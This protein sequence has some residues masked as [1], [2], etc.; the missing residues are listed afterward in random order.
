MFATA[1]APAANAPCCV[2]EQFNCTARL[3]CG[4]ILIWPSVESAATTPADRLKIVWAGK[5]LPGYCQ[6]GVKS[7]LLLRRQIS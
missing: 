4:G 5:C 7:K 6:M 2:G 1:V 3:L